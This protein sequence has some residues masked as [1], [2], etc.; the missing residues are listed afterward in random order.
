MFWFSKRKNK[1]VDPLI[2]LSNVHLD[3]LT[4]SDKEQHTAASLNVSMGSIWDETVPN[5]ATTVYAFLQVSD[6]V[7]ICLAKK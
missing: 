7:G 5:W 1:N 4:M 6:L 3:N 2:T